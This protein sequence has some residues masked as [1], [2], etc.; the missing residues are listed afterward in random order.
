MTFGA[1][2][3]PQG[4]EVKPGE[5][6]TLPITFWWWPGLAGRVYPGRKWRIQEG[7]TLVGIGQVIEVQGHIP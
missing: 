2:E 3:I 4:A 1:L 7:R 5:A 6:I